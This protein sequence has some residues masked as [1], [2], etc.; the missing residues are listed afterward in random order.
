MMRRRN[1]LLGAVGA[2]SIAATRPGSA[3]GAPTLKL[4]HIVATSGVLKGVAEPSVVAADM[5]IA[6]IN[7]QGGVNGR[8]LEL[9]RYDTGSDPRQAA[10]AARK[11]IEDDQVYAILGPFASGEV[12]VAMNDAER[13]HC[14]MFPIAASVPGLIDGKAYLWRMVADEGTQ[15][16][17]VL[18]SLKRKNVDVHSAEVIYISD[19]AV[20]ANAGTKTMP[21]ILDKFGITHGDP[22]AF[23][24]K[25]FDVAPQIAKVLERKPEAIALAALPES[26]SHV[27]KELKRQGFTG[28]VLGSQ[29]FADPNIIDLFGKDGDGAI[30]AAGFWKGSSPEATAFNTQFVENCKARGIN[31]LGVF[32]TDALTYDVVHLLAQSMQ[33][34][35]VGS[36]PAKLDDDRVAI[37]NALNGVSFNGILGKNI[38]FQNHEGH[39]PGYVIEMQDAAWT[40]FDSWPAEACS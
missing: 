31:K 14:T 28:H 4:G 1:L 3:Q 19:E 38:C 37:N 15:F 36:D 39:L 29:L 24:Y 27:V 34:A 40:L 35:K 13:A 12:A 22:V 2:A 32:H 6:D 33:K 17:R 5:A 23:Q 11:L 7:A 16:T 25:T 10:I 21:A 18:N 30:F 26:A 8:K 9:V 20:S